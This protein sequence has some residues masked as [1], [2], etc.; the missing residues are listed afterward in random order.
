MFIAVSI[1]F[2]LNETKWSEPYAALSDIVISPEAIKISDVFLPIS[3]F[4]PKLQVKDGYSNDPDAEN[5]TPSPLK[6]SIFFFLYD[7]SNAS[8][9]VLSKS[10]KSE[11]TT[12]AILVTRTTSSSTSV[13]LQLRFV[14]SWIQVDSK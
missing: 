6:K 2:S 5:L 14:R 7:P 10:P 4:S 9:E 13:L 11:I 1:S 3:A 12:S 8:S